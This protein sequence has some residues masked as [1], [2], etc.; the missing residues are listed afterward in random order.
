MRFKIKYLTLLFLFVIC[1]VAIAGIT[2]KI[3]GKVVDANTGEPLPGANIVLKETT[4]GAATDINGTFLILNVPPG[5][6]ILEVSMIGYSKQFVPDVFVQIDLTTRLDFSLQTEVIK[7]ESITVVA[8]R[9]AV[10]KDLTSSESRISS[11]DISVMPVTE[12]RDILELQSGVT[13]D[14]G[15]GI[16]IR[17][18]RASEVAYWIDGI[19]VTD[20]YDGG[21]SVIVENSS[22]QELQVISGT[23]NAEYGNAM[24]GII[25]IVTKEGAKRF[26]GSF[27][28]YSGDYFSSRDKL[29][30][31]ID[32]IDPLAEKN[33][34]MSLSGPVPLLSEFV[35]F[36][37]TA[38]Y[39]Y[40]DG[41]LYGQSYFDMYGDTL[42]NVEYV[43]MNWRNKL[44]TQSK[45]SFRPFPKLKI[46]LSYMTSEEDYEDFDHGLQYVPEANI[47]RHNIGRNLSIGITHSLSERTFYDLN[48]S[49]Y[50]KRYW[51]KLFEDEN[52]PRYIDPYFWEHDR[53]VNP[54]FWFTDH[55][56]NTNRFQ[57]RTD[58]N[59]AKFDITS[60]ITD[61]HLLKFG[62][63]GKVHKLELDDYSIIDNPN[64]KDTVFT[65]YI[66]KK[67]TL[68]KNFGEFEREYYLHEPKEISVY[69]QDKIEFQN[70][71]INL[72]M[73][74]DYFDADA[75]VPAN[76]NE[77]Y[78]DNPRDP[79]LDSLSLEE[80]EEFWWKDT[81][82]KSQIS[83]RLGI[84][85]PITDKGV[86]HFSFGHFFQIPQFEYLYT[87][88]GY[89]IPET[90]GHFGVF[91]N[92]NMKPQK[93]VMYELGIRQEIVRNLT[94]DVTGFYRDVRDWVSSGIPI[95]LGGGASYYTYVN[96][97]YSNVRGITLS[98]TKSY[99]RYYWFNL[100]Y[101]FQ[102]VE[103][104]N[105]NPDDEFGAIEDNREPRRYIVP[106]EW[107]QAHTINGSVYL[108]TQK[109]GA[110]LIGR[111]GSS[112]PYTP[113][114][115]VASRMGRSISTELETNSRRKPMTCN[116]DLKI[117]R[118]ISVGKSKITLFVDIY[119]LLDV[120]NELIVWGNTGRANK[121]LDEPDTPEEIS[122][123]DSIYRIN[124]IREHYTH[125]EWYSEPR[126]IQF[127]FNIS[128]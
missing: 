32:K 89:K 113:E 110:T 99:S 106:L 93:T 20:V 4:M 63:E 80:R 95:D 53:R 100:Y 116:F 15:G 57:R 117:F 98:L 54:D 52:D 1:H 56:I 47:K 50:Y 26:G 49:R 87:D 115:T 37:T 10:Q 9:P 39:N 102:I 107:D 29:Y 126:K 27:S 65:P 85:Y 120:R 11:E 38:R 5:R 42:N 58:T 19:A 109:G 75:Q 127:G 8:K 3:T 59:I 18:G 17:G 67:D 79:I 118:N 60:Q 82:P 14:E 91:R 44:T 124:T 6:Y 128:L 97:D 101:T 104:S 36:Y 69:I 84:A 66:P 12:M 41:W 55:S 96:K 121:N 51:H 73:R 22:I 16:H 112:Y 114:I 103:G 72:G 83:P 77:P 25:N 45:L 46:R 119:N 48:F 105:S 122:W 28:A 68:G 123:Y 74:W 2:G 21:Q 111:Y 90:S 33:L 70:V 62:I 76:S 64:I 40:T 108:G 81:K 92:P 31:G 94:I 125:P 43:P 71:I 34:Q 61:I 78:I 86:I 88:P 13:L 24:S 30:R 23:F 35:S 7:G